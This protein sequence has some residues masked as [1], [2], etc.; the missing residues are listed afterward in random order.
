MQLRG[1]TLVLAMSVHSLLAPLSYLL[2]HHP[3]NEKMETATSQ[4]KHRV[5]NKRHVPRRHGD[6]RRQQVQRLLMMIQTRGRNVYV[7]GGSYKTLYFMTFFFVFGFFFPS[8][9]Y[10][11]LEVPS[12]SQIMFPFFSSF[13]VVSLYS[14]I[15]SLSH[16]TSCICVLVVLYE[17]W[18]YL[19][20][21]CYCKE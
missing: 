4:R 7:W 15:R 9:I 8:I 5:P 2:L 1:S 20:L 3:G 18:D 6:P 21:I 17:E 16:V 13:V 12:L 14:N 19:L 11:D 10:L